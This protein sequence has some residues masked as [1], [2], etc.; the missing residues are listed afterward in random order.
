MK[1]AGLDSSEATAKVKEWQGQQQ[2]FLSQTGFQR[3]YGRERVFGANP[4]ALPD[5]ISVAD[6]HIGK[7]VGVKPKN[8]DIIDKET[9]IVYN[10]IEGSHLQNS[11]VFAGK[12]VKTPLHQEV[13][14][15]L[16]EQFGGKPS[17][18]QHAKAIAELND[19]GEIR[20][21]EVH[22]FQ[23]KRIG[24]VKLKVKRRIDED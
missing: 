21:A 14:Q 2:E 19:D 22:W 7:S 24:K 8:Y 3:Q 11:T 12:G 20:L 1:A 23:A 4:K 17:D 9:G 16:S 6:I 18:W 5:G 10:F 13:A 15:G